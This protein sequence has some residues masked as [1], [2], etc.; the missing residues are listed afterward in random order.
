MGLLIAGC[1]LVGVYYFGV[2]Y[3]V[4]ISLYCF[5]FYSKLTLNLI[6]RFVASY[7]EK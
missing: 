4:I 7:Y 6:K 1:S 3:M 2:A 5:E